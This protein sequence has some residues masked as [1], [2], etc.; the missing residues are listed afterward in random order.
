[1]EILS[2]KINSI[3]EGTV[4]ERKNKQVSAAQSIISLQNMNYYIYCIKSNPMVIQL[5][6][7]LK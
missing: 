7:F 6:R 3:Y 1:M 5:C 4:I 2:L